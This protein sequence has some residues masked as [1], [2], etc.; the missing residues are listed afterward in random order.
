MVKCLSR[1]D[2]CLPLHLHCVSYVTAMLCMPSIWAARPDSPA[3]ADSKYPKPT[4]MLF[5]VIPATPHFN[6]TSVVCPFPLLPPCRPSLSQSLYLTWV[7]FKFDWT[8]EAVRAK[9]LI[10]AGELDIELEDDVLADLPLDK[11]D[12]EWDRDRD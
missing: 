1:Q 4:A 12:R 8:A 10:A 7:V 9:G 2:L 6:R 11:L 5:S 3:G